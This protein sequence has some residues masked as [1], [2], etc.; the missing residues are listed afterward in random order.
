MRLRTTLGAAVAAL[1]IGIGFIGCGGS[2]GGSTTSAVNPNAGD[3]SPAGDIPDNQAFVPYAPPGAGFTVKVPEG[4]SLSA[5]PGGA[6]TFTDKLNSVKIETA[7]AGAAPTVYQVKSQVVPQLATT[8]A[9]FQLQDVAPVTRNGG[10][11]ILITYLAN[12]KPNAVTGKAGQNAVEEYVFFKNGK[13]AILTLSG[14]NGADNVDPWR[15]ITDSL[16]WTA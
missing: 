8:V 16:Q 11:G 13:E 7:S 10:D 1:A 2:S 15:I 5:S 12:A 4:W 14:P 6:T 9:G 3:V